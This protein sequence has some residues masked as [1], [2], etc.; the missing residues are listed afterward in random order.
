M[1]TVASIAAATGLRSGGV[2]ETLHT[3]REGGYVDNQ[4]GGYWHLTIGGVDALKVAS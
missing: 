3:L 4:A 2:Y 1:Q